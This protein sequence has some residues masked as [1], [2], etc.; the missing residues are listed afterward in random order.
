[1]R[2]R[3]EQSGFGQ[4]ALRQRA[5]ERRRRKLKLLAQLPILR[6]PFPELRQDVS[7]LQGQHL[8]IG[9]HQ[10]TI[11]KHLANRPTILGVDQ[12]EG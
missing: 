1:M 10:A 6:Q 11:D 9:H 12:V 3:D 7:L 5:N 8:T 2:Q 4:F